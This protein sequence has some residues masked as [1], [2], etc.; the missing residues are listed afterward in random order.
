MA[1]FPFSPVVVLYLNDWAGKSKLHAL[2]DPVFTYHDQDI[3]LLPADNDDDDEEREIVRTPHTAHPGTQDGDD[4]PE[5]VM[6]PP[7]L[8]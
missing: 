4:A 8:E 2:R 3:T 5:L 6:I 7:T 1:P